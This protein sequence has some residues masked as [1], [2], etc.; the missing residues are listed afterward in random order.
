M[1]IVL[2]LPEVEVSP[3][4]HPPWPHPAYLWYPL[5]SSPTPLRQRLRDIFQ[6]KCLFNIWC[7][8]LCY[9]LSIIY[10]WGCII[11]AE[12]KVLKNSRLCTYLFGKF[13]KDLTREARFVILIQSFAVALPQRLLVLKSHFWSEDC[14]RIMLHNN[15][16]CVPS[17]WRRQDQLERS[18]RHV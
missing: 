18:V 13:W 2:H 4:S 7:L 6:K 3:S 11:S 8:F 12:V 14:D 9:C 16:Q 1:H 17:V 15:V 5:C 10:S